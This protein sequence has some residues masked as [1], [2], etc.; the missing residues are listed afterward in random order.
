MNISADKTIRDEFRSGSRF[1]FGKNWQR[2]LA[3]IDKGSIEEAEQ[4]M[5]EF[6]G[7]SSLANK[8]FLDCRKRQRTAKSRGVPPR[9]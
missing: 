5:K 8:R 2:F 4:H 9:R 3:T 6:L 1:R 7:D